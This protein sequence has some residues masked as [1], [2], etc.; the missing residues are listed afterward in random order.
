MR[1]T[2]WSLFAAVALS[3][4]ALLAACKQGEGDR[5][6]VQ[7]DCQAGLTCE[8]LRET[9][10]GT[11]GHCTSNPGAVIP[12]DAAPD[13]GRLDAVAADAGRDAG[14]T[15]SATQD[16]PRDEA[17]ADGAADGSARPADGVTE[18]AGEAPVPDAGADSGISDAADVAAGS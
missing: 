13:V 18:R 5:C 11:S 12:L 15:D 6:E 14:P 3:A 7:N 2:P 1:R 9:A 17:A 16:A 8:N 4:S 10:Q